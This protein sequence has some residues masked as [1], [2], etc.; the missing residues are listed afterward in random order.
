M[1]L[2]CGPCVVRF[3][4]QDDLPDLL[5]HADNPKVAAT[6]RDRFPYPYTETDGR[7]WLDLATGPLSDTNWAIEVTG[8]AAGGIG[9]V[10]QD[11]I[12]AGTAEVG[13]WLGETFW[14]RGIVTAALTAVTRHA[15]T[16]LGYRRLFATVFAPNV[17][18]QRVLEKA[19]YRREG[20]LR[21]SAIKHGV[22]L[23]QMLYAVTDDDPSSPACAGRASGWA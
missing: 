14:N 21:R 3:W 8:E 2:A 19:G 7:A 20:L 17:A 22:V 1:H 12:N 18:S 15:L 4:R 5:R 23:D 11:D 6:M 16:V 9:L 13:Y 10:P